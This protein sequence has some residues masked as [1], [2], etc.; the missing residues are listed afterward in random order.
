ME[1]LWASKLLDLHLSRSIERLT[2]TSKFRELADGIKQDRQ[3]FDDQATE[4]L[5]KREELRL[6][7]E[8]VFAKHREHHSEVESGLKAL[9]EVVNDLEGSNSKNGE[10]S[11]DMSESFQGSQAKGQE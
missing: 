5:K 3:N 7:G 6:R 2:M 1:S 4:L 9:E 8:K 11:G 10:G